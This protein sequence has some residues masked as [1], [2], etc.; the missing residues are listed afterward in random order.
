VE[1]AIKDQLVD[2]LRARAREGK[3]DPRP[4]LR[5]HS[6][7]GDLIQNDEF[8]LALNSALQMLYSRGAQAALAHYLTAS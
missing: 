3:E 5:L 2:E 6:L 1:I 8:V 7:F 4:L